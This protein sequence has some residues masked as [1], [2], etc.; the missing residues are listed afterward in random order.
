MFSR[1][2]QH[3]KLFKKPN[4]KIYAD[5]AT[6]TPISEGV[7]SA[8][9][10]VYREY[11]KNPSALY[12]SAVVSKKRLEQARKQIAF[13]LSGLSIHSIHSD[14]IYF[15]SGGTESNNI[16]ISGVVHSWYE[17]N[18]NIPHVV[19][20]N[21][22]HPAVKKVIEDLVNKKLIT[23]SYIP[24][25]SD[26]V[27]DLS[28]LKNV[29]DTQS[30]IVLISIML[31]NNEIG[32]IQP[33]KDI[34]KIIRHYKKTHHTEY[35][36]FHTDACQA[37]CYIDMPIDMFGIDMMSLDGGKIYGPR[38]V[39]CLYI[40][41]GVEIVSIEKGGGQENGLRP[42]TENLPA[43]VGFE[44]ALGDVYSI[45]SKEIERIG[46]MQKYIIEN[47]PK[48]VFVNGSTDTKKRIVNNI[49]ICF[50]GKDSEF[51]VFQID[52][53]GV[54]VSAVTACQNSEVESRSFVV[55]ALGGECGGSSI[56][57]SLGRYTTW[58]DV[59]KI[60]SVIQKLGKS[61]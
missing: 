22:E 5:Y 14:E 17:K 6:L 61:S 47:L 30:N 45:R 37:P 9:S 53:A 18:T 33:L 48:D 60:V 3:F 31:V 58:K 50:P 38:G 36:Y 20:S 56:R 27:I 39:G 40:K 1:I 24:V 4:K 32:T 34:A 26:G 41:R 13:L 59:K 25:T 11:D 8:M 12:T 49:N 29:F 35:P 44:T 23:A 46:D 7:L 2:F 54:E 28:F 19:T 10:R 55:D 16:A 21:I 15:T 43:I 57:I 42:G 51:M 52:V